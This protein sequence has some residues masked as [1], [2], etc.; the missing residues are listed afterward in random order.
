MN[1]GN[2]TT[3]MESLQVLLT[4]SPCFQCSALC[5][6]SGCTAV[7]NV[8]S[9]MPAENAAVMELKV[10][11]PSRPQASP[12]SPGE[13]SDTEFVQCPA[14]AQKRRLSPIGDGASKGKLTGIEVIEK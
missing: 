4:L 2:D 9:L 12:T 1:A 10:P 7:T 5:C 11:S 3:M 6:L 13:D 8:A 14:L